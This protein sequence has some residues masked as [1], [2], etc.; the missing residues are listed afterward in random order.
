MSAKEVDA[1][2]GEDEEAKSVLRKHNSNKALSI[3]FDYQHN[4]RSEILNGMYVHLEKGAL[5]L[6]GV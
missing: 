1:L 2:V 4:F 6:R 5:G 3:A